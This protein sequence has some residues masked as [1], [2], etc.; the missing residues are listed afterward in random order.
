VQELV[1]ARK[2]KGNIVET[3]ICNCRFVK[4][5]GKYGFEE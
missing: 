3:V 5:L 2:R 1:V 4:L